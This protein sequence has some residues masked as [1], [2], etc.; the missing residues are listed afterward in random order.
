FLSAILFAVNN[1]LIRK[2]IKISKSKQDNGVLITII[3]N[4]II[5]GLAFLIYRLIFKPSI[6]F[7]WL[8]LIYFILAGFLTIFIGRV[9]FFDGINRIGP[10]KAAAIKNSAPMFTLIF[11][12]LILG[13]TVTVGPL[14]GILLI[15]T[16]ILI[17][18]YSMFKKDQQMDKFGFIISGVAA[19]SF[20]LGQGIRKLGLHLYNDPFA[21][22]FI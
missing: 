12:I 22:A 4:V 6:D 10:S 7:S 13:E 15:I 9:T 20:G 14:I 17:Q 19:L 21:G 2:G 16:A 11:A 8:G 3:I 18:S 1:V 5:L